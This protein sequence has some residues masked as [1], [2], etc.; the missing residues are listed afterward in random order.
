MLVERFPIIWRRRDDLWD[1]VALTGLT[2]TQDTWKPAPGA[3]GGRIVPLL[4]RAYPLATRD[5]GQE[6]TLR[7][8]VDE[9][10]LLT[11]WHPA[12][13]Q[14]DPQAGEAA[15]EQRLNALW[16]FANSRRALQAAY[17]ALEADGALR[18]WELGFK[19]ET[20]AI[21]LEGFH[22]VDWGY[23]G[24]AAHERLVERYGWLCASLLALHR[25]SLHRVNAMLRDLASRQDAA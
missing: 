13:R 1:L 7:V 15:L 5:D 17:R 21:A 10:A 24:G 16:A 11:P 3:S 14:Y 19:N 18:P 4:L 20:E 25:I 2:P 22:Y 9:P 6:E 12:V 23:F 8:L